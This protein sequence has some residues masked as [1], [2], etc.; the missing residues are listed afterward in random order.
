M[1]QNLRFG[2][3]ASQ[4]SW[5]T[6]V[7]QW[8]HVEALGFDSVWIDDS[9]WWT[10]PDGKPRGPW[11]EV[12][13]LLAGLAAQTSRIRI[14]TLV[15]SIAPGQGERLPRLPRPARDDWP[16]VRLVDELYDRLL[17]APDPE[18]LAVEQ[19]PPLGPP[20]PIRLKRRGAHKP[21]AGGADGEEL[22]GVHSILIPSIRPMREF[23]GV[24]RPVSRPVPSQV[25]G[26]RYSRDTI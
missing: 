26:G 10:N 3:Y 12:W 25:Q 13:T 8:R 6:M 1:S 16:V 23:G 20:I 5:P 17:P 11:F 19:D 4:G 22:G 21:R 14:G 15:T 24:V 7:E 9:P 18:L 2:L